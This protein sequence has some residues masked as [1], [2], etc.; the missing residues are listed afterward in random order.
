MELWNADKTR[1]IA[2]NLCPDSKLISV[3]PADKNEPSWKDKSLVHSKN[4]LLRLSEML[5]TWT[6]QGSPD[7]PEKKHIDSHDL[8]AQKGPHD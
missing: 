5:C 3:A 2:N 6:K 4:L 7:Q 8:D 1:V